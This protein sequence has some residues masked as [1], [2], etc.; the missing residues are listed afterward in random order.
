MSMSALKLIPQPEFCEILRSTVWCNRYLLDKAGRN[1]IIP[2]PQNGP[3]ARDKRQFLVL[4]PLRSTRQSQRKYEAGASGF[5]GV[6]LSSSG[7]RWK[8]RIV[9]GGKKHHLGTFDTKQ[10]AALAYTTRRQGSADRPS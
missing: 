6:R 4:S 7:E 5:Y 9:Y 3:E 2:K 10:E 1:A 8:A